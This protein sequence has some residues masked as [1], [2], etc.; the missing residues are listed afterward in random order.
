MTPQDLK[1]YLDL[2]APYGIGGAGVIFIIL[3]RESL[4]HT[5]DALVD[6]LASW[7]KK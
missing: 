3:F 2:L 1:E 7:A 6:V 5:W 4:I